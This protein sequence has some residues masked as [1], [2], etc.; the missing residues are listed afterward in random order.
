[1]N[2]FDCHHRNQIL[3]DYGE[4]TILRN[5]LFS[6]FHRQHLHETLAII[7]SPSLSLL[8]PSLS[9]LPLHCSY[10]SP[11]LTLY[12]FHTLFS[13][14]TE[15]HIIYGRGY[16]CILF[17]VFFTELSILSHSNNA[18][19]LLSIYDVK[20]LCVLW[21]YCFYQVIRFI[22]VDHIRSFHFIYVTYKLYIFFINKCHLNVI[23]IKWYCFSFLLE[24]TS[25]SYV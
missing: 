4:S 18:F 17:Y 8:S 3:F 11:S 2:V 15:K 22:D 23:I 25:F 12:L 9:L 20:S 10:F 16:I 24:I 19:G 14:S 21:T 5:K 7:L 1:M 6:I 13:F